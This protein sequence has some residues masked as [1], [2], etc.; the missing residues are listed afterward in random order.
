MYIRGIPQ[1]FNVFCYLELLCGLGLTH[2]IGLDPQI[3]ELKNDCGNDRV[4]VLV[5]RGL[6]RL[7][8][9]GWVGQ[10]G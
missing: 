4:R 8:C 6:T 9:Q 2:R 7:V 5:Y 3:V 1:T 10:F